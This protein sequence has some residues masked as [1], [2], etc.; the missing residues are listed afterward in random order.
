MLRID[1]DG[2]A[3]IALSVRDAAVDD[4]LRFRPSLIYH[5]YHLDEK[6]RLFGK[7]V[8]QIA[9]IGRLLMPFA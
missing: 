6:T 2:L 5:K 1:A 7:P 9:T 8:D 4:S 3:E